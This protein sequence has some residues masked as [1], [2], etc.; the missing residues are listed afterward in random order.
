MKIHYYKQ[1]IID[2]CDGEHFTID[3]IVHELQSTFKEVGKSS[4]YRNL[5]ELVKEGKLKK[6]NWAWD[7]A[8]F[9]KNKENHIH[10]IDT[11]S[12]EIVDFDI[13]DISKTLKLPNNFKTEDF[14]R[15]IYGQ[16]A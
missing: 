12:G 9:E 1:Y 2:I 10:L 15:K 16:F 7:K 11:K 14:D 4:V 3:D 6:L 5:Q 13:K 8:Y